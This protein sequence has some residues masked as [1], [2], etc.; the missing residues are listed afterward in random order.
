MGVSISPVRR[1]A[2]GA[3]GKGSPR[4]ASHARADATVHHALLPTSLGNVLLSATPKG[5]CG[6]HFTDQRDCPEIP[7]ASTRVERLDDPSAGQWQGLPMRRIKVCPQGTSEQRLITDTA[8][9]TVDAC[10]LQF[11]DS[12]MPAAAR[13]ILEQAAAELAAYARGER[14]SFSVPLEFI[15]GTAFQQA[16]WHAMCSIPQGQVVS[17]G[18]LALRTGKSAGHGRAVGAAVGANPVSII[19]PC[20]RVVAGNRQLNGYG[21]GLL[22]KLRLLQL[23]GVPLTA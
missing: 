20:H 3:T 2:V 23:E 6:L 4:V 19:V 12:T 14:H 13:A 8:P 10:P 21:G 7:G 18:E 15:E 17:Y 1:A 22:R 16:I 5:L 11:T 9:F